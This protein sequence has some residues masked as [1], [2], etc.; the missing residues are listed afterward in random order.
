[1]ANQTRFTQRQDDVFHHVGDKISKS[2]ESVREDEISDKTRESNKKIV[3]KL[4]IGP[5]NLK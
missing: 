1:M 5:Q 4:D 2:G 3:S